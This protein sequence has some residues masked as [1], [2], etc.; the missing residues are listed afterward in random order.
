MKRGV[1]VAPLALLLALSPLASAAEGDEPRPAATTTGAAK[2]AAPST[3]AASANAAQAPHPA[4]G[5]GAGDGHDDEDGTSNPHAANPHGHGGHGGGDDMFQAPQDGAMDDPTLPVGTLDIHIVDPT[6]NALPN[7]NVTLGVLHNSVAK[8]ESR[9]RLSVTTNDKGVARLEQLETGSTVA[10]RPMVIT[11]GATFSVMPFR[12]PER[13]GMRAILHVYPV[14]ESIESALIVTQSVI[15][16]EVKDDRIQVQQ[17]FKVYNFGKNA[18]VPK[19]LVVPLP[20]NFTAFTTQQGMSDVGVD[21]VPGKGVRIHGTF[22][23]GQHM[24]EFRWQLPYSREAEVRFDVGMTPR[25]AASRVIAPASKDM[26]LDVPGFPP[27]Q[28][29]SDGMGQRALITEKQLRKEDP[30]LSTVSVVIRGLPSEGPGKIIATLLAAGGLLVGLV[31]G[32]QK[33][34]D[35]DRKTER[36]RLLAELEDLERARLAGDVG[37]KTYAKARRELIDALTRTFADEAPVAKPATRRSPRSR[38]A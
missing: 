22:G 34:S 33:R 27:P 14:V 26:T 15:Y 13:T 4:A 1:F 16:T 19:D 28:S 10:Y 8:G 30:T 38:A 20:E 32:A 37:P 29:T 7:T 21:A 5:P 6:G 36:D 12:M 9:K 35:R 2:A 17:A 24:L 11:E 3:G 25:M 18:W 23:P 31:L